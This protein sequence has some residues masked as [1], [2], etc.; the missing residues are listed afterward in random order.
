MTTM[1]KES[2]AE[3]LEA[4][5]ARMAWC[6]PHA[7]WQRIFVEEEGRAVQFAEAMLTL[8]HAEPEL[9]LDGEQ[10]QRVRR[11]LQALASSHNGKVD[12]SAGAS[13]L[14][15]FQSP[16][17]ALRM[18]L[19]IQRLGEGVQFRTGVF[20]GLC[21]LA[22]FEAKGQRWFVVVGAERGQSAEMAWNAV[23]G[24][25]A[26]SAASYHLL[27]DG[28]EEEVGGALVSQEF[29]GNELAQ[30]TVILPPR[31][32]AFQSSFAGLGLT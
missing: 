13:S 24:T 29:D 16:R 2:Q 30:A 6:M 23:A 12:R 17:A 4:L 10:A 31:A 18:A 19:G 8:V 15:V 32:N 22:F 5:S 9:P 27:G 21:T 1:A 20:T 25:I 7:E 11:E 28:L 26:I 3:Q 14:T